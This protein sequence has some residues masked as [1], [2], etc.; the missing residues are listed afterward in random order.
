MKKKG[1]KAVATNRR[2]G[3]DYIMLEKFVAGIVLTGTEI[4]SVRGGKVT[5]QGGFVQVKS[6]ELYLFDVHIAP[7]ERAG[8]QA[9][10]PTRPRKLLLHRREIRKIMDDLATK[11]LTMVPTKM[12]LK[13][14]WAKVE[15][16]LAR[17]KK[18][19]DKRAEIA[20]RDAERRVE[21]ALSE[22]YKS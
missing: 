9:H 16:A 22:K 5:L 14:G 18:K 3:R 1:T 7:Y 2:A 12:F 17:G 4:K 6:G 10:D 8:H 21:R 11:G 15:I 13:D 19:Y 20:K